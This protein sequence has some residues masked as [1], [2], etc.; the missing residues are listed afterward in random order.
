MGNVA[1]KGR[2]GSQVHELLGEGLARAGHGGGLHQV[3]HA[4]HVAVTEVEGGTAPTGGE[5]QGLGEG[6][7]T[8]FR[9]ICSRPRGAKRKRVY[10]NWRAG[11]IL[12]T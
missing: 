2:A 9:D 12:D 5:G 8:I 10:R 11:M 7:S 1:A 4:T 3:E 6:V